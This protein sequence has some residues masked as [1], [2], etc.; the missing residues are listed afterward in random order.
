MK[1][2]V[3]FAAEQKKDQQFIFHC[4]F[5]FPVLKHLLSLSNTAMT[6]FSKNYCEG[7]WKYF[8]FVRSRFLGIIHHMNAKDRKLMVWKGYQTFL[9]LENLHELHNYFFNMMVFPSS[10][11][12]RGLVVLGAEIW[13]ALATHTSTSRPELRLTLGGYREFRES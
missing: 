4:K 12:Q 10:R 11:S 8:K 5:R 13:E 1:F 9:L 2:W 7:V 3:V 6:S